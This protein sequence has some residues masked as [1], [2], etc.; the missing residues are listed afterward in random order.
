MSALKFHNAIMGEKI[1]KNSAV[2]T[3][4]AQG[5]QIDN[6]RKV[7]LVNNTIHDFV[8]YGLYA[9][10]SSNIVLENNILSGVRPELLPLANLTLLEFPFPTGGFELGN[11]TITSFVIRNN[12][13]SGTWNMG[14]RLHSKNCGDKN[15]DGSIPGKFQKFHEVFK[16]SEIDPQAVSMT[17]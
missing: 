6:S 9:E 1:M 5:I 10:R 13:A 16:N 12:T 3:G 2:S 4:P 17:S 11:D 14:F 8:L 15:D 7:T